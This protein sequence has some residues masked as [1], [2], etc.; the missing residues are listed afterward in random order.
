MRKVLILALILAALVL[1]A[2]ADDAT[3]PTAD[4][5]EIHGGAYPAP[6]DPEC[7][8]VFGDIEDSITITP[9]TGCSIIEVY[10][11]PGTDG[12]YDLTLTR[13]DGS[14]ITSSVIQSRYYVVASDHR[15]EIEG[16]WFNSTNWVFARGD[17]RIL[18]GVNSN[19]SAYYFLGTKGFDSRRLEI[20]TATGYME[21]PI[22]AVKIELAGGGPFYYSVHMRHDDDL[23]ADMEQTIGIQ[24]IEVI[25]NY[26]TF[27]WELIQT[28]LA[29]GYWL[30]YGLGFL[31][32]LM[33]F[34]LGMSAYY[35][36]TSR[37]IFQF[38]KK[39]LK[40]NKDFFEFLSGMLHSV[41]QILV[42]IKN[43]IPFL[44]YL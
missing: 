26:L 38:Y 29:F 39:M 25:R 43:M 28:I 42:N 20:P 30:I 18:W 4:I 17:G 23:G 9:P 32:I 31:W 13:G 34:E 40:G 10:L 24:P 11:A 22:K 12:T 16:K 1:P 21:N 6:V 41:S 44:K 37:D 8:V 27:G 19:T 3:A 2:L 33:V 15:F 35:S 7:S 36:L 5:V 14:I